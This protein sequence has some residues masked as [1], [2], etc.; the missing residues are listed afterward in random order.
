MFKWIKKFL[1]L[2]RPIF[3]PIN[4]DPPHDTFK[5]S[6]NYE[7]GRIYYVALISIFL[8]SAFIPFYIMLHP[9][10]VLSIITIGGF[11]LTSLII[12]LM[13]LNIMP[14]IKVDYVRPFQVFL[15]YLILA[16]ALLTGMAGENRTVF[17]VAYAFALM[18]PIY[19]PFSLRYKACIMG[20]AHIIFTIS[21]IATGFDFTNTVDLLSFLI[22]LAVFGCSI[23]FSYSLN[24]LRRRTWQQQRKLAEMMIEVES[25]AR[26]EAE[27]VAAKQASKSKS[28]FL[29]KMSHEIRTPMNAIMGMTELA[30]R[31]NL[32]KAAKEYMFTVIQASQYLLSIINDILDISKIESGRIDL[33]QEEYSLSSVICDTVNIARTKVYDTRLRFTVFVDSHM[34]NVLLGDAAK[35][36]QIMLN[37]LS[38][39]VKFTEIGFVSLSISSQI[40]GE[41]EILLIIEVADSGRGIRQS[42]IRKLF[43]EFSQLD[44]HKS[45]EIE[46]S[47]LGLAITRTFVN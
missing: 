3:I 16:M 11:S 6:L 9:F 4:D 36:R 42:D 5:S 39:A 43:K 32:P 23:I 24:D 33:L 19:T 28:D 34:P 35:I 17:M 15:S 37:L 38:N 45:F 44:D 41:D 1:H 30:L 18:T 22:L 26:I 46:G 14:W 8:W 25:K 7:A 40:T 47:G 27:M 12:V 10:P 2:L 20:I 21:L 13:R 29:A 31:E